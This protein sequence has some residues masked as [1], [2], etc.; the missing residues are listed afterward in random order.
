MSA[1]PRSP[2]LDALDWVDYAFQPAGEPPP[3][4]GLWSSGHSA[5]VVTDIHNFP[6]KTVMQMA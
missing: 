1:M 6:L 3:G 5:V 4:C 2:L